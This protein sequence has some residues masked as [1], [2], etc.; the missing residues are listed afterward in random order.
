MQLYPNKIR[1][2]NTPVISYK[3]GKR[4]SVTLFGFMT[5]NGK[6]VAMTSEETK[7]ENMLSFTELI[8]KEN[9]EEDMVIILD[10]AKIHHAKIVTH[11]AEEQKICFVHI[12]PYSP[13]LNP[14]EYGVKDIKRE[15]AKILDSDMMVEESEYIG[16]KIFEEGKM[17][18][19]KS[20][21]KEFISDKSC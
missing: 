14:I 5:L 11:F 20:W 12:P 6:D 13:D 19:T 4:K 15:L 1:V 18:Y 21:R 8:R 10:N 3:S 7:K 16:I 2:I 17:S 9:P